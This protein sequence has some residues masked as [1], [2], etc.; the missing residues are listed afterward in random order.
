MSFSS[1]LSVIR[2]V[3]FIFFIFLLSISAGLLIIQRKNIP[4][5][6]RWSFS[7]YS[8]SWI[9][10][11]SGRRLPWILLRIVL[12]SLPRVHFSCAYLLVLIFRYLLDC[13]IE[14]ASC[15][16]TLASEKFKKMHKAD[17]NFVFCHSCL[18]VLCFVAAFGDV[19]FHMFSISAWVMGSTWDER[20]AGP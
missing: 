14:G 11:A 15:Y 1:F 19:A 7:T 10:R 8:R 9:L 17:I 3:F 4:P 20:A 16:V 2:Y 5:W 13:S 18:F 6:W 12:L